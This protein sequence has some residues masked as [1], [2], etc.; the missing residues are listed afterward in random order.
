MEGIYYQLIALS[1]WDDQPIPFWM[2]LNWGVMWN[3]INTEGTEINTTKETSVIVAQAGLKPRSPEYPS[4]ILTHQRPDIRSLVSAYRLLR[5]IEGYRFPW[6]LT[7]VS[8]NHASSNPGQTTTVTIY[9]LEIVITRAAPAF[10]KL[11]MVMGF[12]IN[13]VHKTVEKLTFQ[14]FYWS[15]H[16]CK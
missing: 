15:S 9:T 1:R 4:D 2:S 8:A 3:S 12:D 6:Y 14:A 5:V 11:F 16:S 10:Y 7:L 13:T